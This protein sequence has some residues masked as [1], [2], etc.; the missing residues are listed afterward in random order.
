MGSPL[1]PVIANIYMEKFEE[2]ALDTAT[3]KPFFW[4]R[5]VDDTFVIWQHGEA[6][7]QTFLNH[8]NNR[9]ESI[10][11]TMEKEEA[12]SIPFLDV[13]VSKSGKTLTT[14]VYRKKTH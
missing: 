9:R 8:L 7:L 11:F 14:S 1:S 10:Q 3:D 5:Y 12:G 13:L 6:K 2:E 4:V